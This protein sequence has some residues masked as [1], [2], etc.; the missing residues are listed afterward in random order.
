MH[1]LSALPEMA[2]IKIRQVFIISALALYPYQ[3]LVARV[4]TGVFEVTLVRVIEELG[5]VEVLWD[6]GVKRV[7]KWSSVV[8]GKTDGPVEQMPSQVA[9]HGEL[10]TL[11]TTITT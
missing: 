3:L 1:E 2:R 8:F 4:S 10:T 5:S 11:L 7:F 6:R 9:A